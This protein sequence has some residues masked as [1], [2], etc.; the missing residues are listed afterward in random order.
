[1][2]DRVHSR[3]NPKLRA[4]LMTS[5]VLAFLAVLAIQVV[6][7]IEQSHATFTERAFASIPGAASFAA[8][9]LARWRLVRLTAAFVLWFYSLPL[10]LVFYIPAAILQTIS[11]FPPYYSTEQAQRA[12]REST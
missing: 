7:T 8:L 6:Q 11:I 2:K 12:S 4:L 1:M 3:A 5:A 10:L 9:A